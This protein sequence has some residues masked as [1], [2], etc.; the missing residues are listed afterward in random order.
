MYFQGLKVHRT[1]KDDGFDV[2]DKIGILLFL[3]R[4]YSASLFCRL[5]ILLTNRSNV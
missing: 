1:L 5:G 2:S 4:L 3:V